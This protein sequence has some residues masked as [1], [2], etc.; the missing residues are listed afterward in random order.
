MAGPS[1][2]AFFGNFL[3]FDHTIQDWTSYKMQ[4]KQWFLANDIDASSDKAGVKKRA[5]MLSAFSENTYKLAS[6]LV[7][8]KLLEDLSFDD[9]VK[10]LDQHF[11]PRRCG[12]A[13][14]YHFYA[15]AQRADETH[16]QWAARL[17]GLAAHCNFKDLENS[18]L[19]KFV[20]GMLPG[21]EREKMFAMDT[22]DLS[23]A[24]AVDVAESVRCARAGAAAAA[25]SAPPGTL[26]SDPVFAIAKG[27]DGNQPASDSERCSV[28]GRKSHKSNQCR[29]ARY[30]CTKC[31]MKGHLR[32]MCK[33]VNFVDSGEVDQGD[34]DVLT[35]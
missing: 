19:D 32:R 27:S 6:N 26:S 30:K 5:I 23:L 1:S 3:R 14:R 18:L 22:K 8:P 7:L 24:K 21:A 11:T 12:F 34:D 25:M 29:F 17:R 15:A 31:N 20:M 16:A 2:S 9:I 10:E 35:E 13:E 33:R 4:L 28:C